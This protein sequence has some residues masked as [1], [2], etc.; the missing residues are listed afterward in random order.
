MMCYVL[1]HQP[2]GKNMVR[3]V[4]ITYFD[5]CVSICAVEQ[6]LVVQNVRSVCPVK[7]ILLMIVCEI[8]SNLVGF[9]KV[10][11][12]TAKEVVEGS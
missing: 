12:S 6:P 3:L 8:I 1:C 10:Y 11:I 9:K 7:V 2:V 5:L 4:G